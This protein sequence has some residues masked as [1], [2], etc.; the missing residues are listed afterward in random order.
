MVMLGGSA[1]SGASGLAGA[2]PP[3][4]DNPAGV[5]DDEKHIREPVPK[6]RH[7]DITGTGMSPESFMIGT[8]SE[9]EDSDT[10]QT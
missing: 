1:G 6:G 9:N 10:E 8:D 2:A 4:A 5:T 7:G 3:R